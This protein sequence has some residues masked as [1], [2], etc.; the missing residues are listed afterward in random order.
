MLANVRARTPHHVVHLMSTATVGG[1]AQARIVAGLA[2]GLDPARYRLHAWFL[3]GPGP[4]EQMLAGAGVAPRH[5]PFAGVRDLRGALRYARAL[6]EERP[7]LV[8]LHLGGGSLALLARR[9]SSAKLVAHIHAACD[10]VGVPMRVEPLVRRAGAVIATSSAVRAA[11]V[12]SADVVYPGIDSR[13]PAPSGRDSLVIGTAGRLEPVKRIDALIEAT[14][15]LRARHPRLRLLIAGEGSLRAGLERLVS[16]LAIADGVQFIGW[17]PNL[18]S[19]HEEVDIFVMPSAHEGFGIAALEAMAAGVPVVGSDVEGLRELVEDGRSGLLVPVGDI[20]ALTDRIELLLSNAALRKRIGD[21]AR[22]RV[23][24][25]F[26][27]E[28][29]VRGIEAVYERLLV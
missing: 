9:L 12:P 5:V 6:A 13:P 1:T 26:T 3:A 25:C 15:R 28:R 23:E 19:F 2:E 7:S 21:A 8:H 18:S 16:E 10:D 11:I 17:E 27:S 22:E 29:M 4:L 24:E 20:D 14:A